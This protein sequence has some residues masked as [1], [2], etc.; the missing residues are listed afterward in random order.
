MKPTP[1]VSIV[2]P[3]HNTADFLSEGIES[4]LRQTY[5]HWEYVLVD[6]CSTDGSREI[7]DRYASRC[8]GK[9]RVIQTSSL[10]SQVQNYNF[11]LNCISPNSKYCKMVQAD[12]WLFPDCTRSMVEV[13][14]M[15]TSVGIVSAYQLEG[16]EVRLDGL[17]YPSTKLAGRDVCRLYFL[18]GTYLFGSPTSLLM[19]SDLIR[20][21]DPFYDQ[22]YAPFEDCHVCFDLL[23]ACDFGFIHQVLT[24][25]R[26]D[27]GGITSSVGWFG[28]EPFVRLTMLV[29]HGKDYLSEGEYDLCLKRAEREYF[30]HLSRAACSL[31]RESRDFWEFHR[32]G[33]ASI[34]YPPGLKSVW[35]W[36]PRAV[37]EKTWDAFWRKWD[38]A[39]RLNL[40]N[41]RECQQSQK[42]VNESRL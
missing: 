37:L 15:Y 27:N 39:P 4:V 19:R 30:M 13:A 18:T 12:D 21:R 28:L 42:A 7:A 33:L 16:D 8:P 22:R 9:I 34:N 25:S 31:R 11:A 29:A 10:L 23:R 35:K 32:N 40:P 20:S 41:R 36:I 2:T 14:E 24:Y 38:N 5:D 17:P 1:L 3:F 26:K 6:N